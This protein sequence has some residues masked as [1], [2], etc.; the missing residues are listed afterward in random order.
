IQAPKEDLAADRPRWPAGQANLAATIENG[1]VKLTWARA[2]GNGVIGYDV[3]R[4][5][6][7]GTAGIIEAVKAAKFTDRLVLGGLRYTYYVM[8]FDKSGR[9]S[10]PSNAVRI[11]MPMPGFAAPAEPSETS[12]ALAHRP[13]RHLRARQPAGAGRLAVDGLHLA[14]AELSAATQ[15]RRGA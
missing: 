8:A 6:D 12:H 13:P 10:P 4:A 1:T 9:H 5:E 15:L 2:A 7:G 14:G 11:D 3:F